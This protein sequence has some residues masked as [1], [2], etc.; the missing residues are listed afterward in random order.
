MYLDAA[1]YT[2]GLYYVGAAFEHKKEVSKSGTGVIG[3]NNIILGR[4]FLH[5]FLFSSSRVRSS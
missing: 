1:Q 4:G 5:T 3:Q 2:E